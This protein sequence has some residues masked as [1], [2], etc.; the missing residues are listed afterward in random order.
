MIRVD[1]RWKSVPHGLRIVWKT[2]RQAQPLLRELPM[3]V[4]PAALAPQALPYRRR[5]SLTQIPALSL[6][7]ILWY[8]VD[9]FRKWRGAYATFRFERPPPPRLTAR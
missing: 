1:G 6:S 9:S 8:C 2:R 7:L 3:I 5:S 4:A